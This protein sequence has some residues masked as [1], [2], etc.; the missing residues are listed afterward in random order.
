MWPCSIIQPPP[1]KSLTRRRRG[2][3]AP[4]LPWICGTEHFQ[5]SAGRNLGMESSAARQAKLFAWVRQTSATGPTEPGVGCRQFHNLEHCRLGTPPFSYVWNQNG[6]VLNGQTANTITLSPSLER[7]RNVF[8]ASDRRH[9]VV[10]N[11]AVLTLPGQT[12]LTATLNEGNYT[13]W[14]VGYTGWRLQTQTGAWARTGQ[15]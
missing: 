5:Q 13:D 15:M 4:T 11:S 1:H 8:G 9:G 7:R 6:T 3:S 12:N 10:T 2:I 14:P